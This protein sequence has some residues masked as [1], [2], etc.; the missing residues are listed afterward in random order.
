MNTH[1]LWDHAMDHLRSTADYPDQLLA[2]WR[3]ET[4]DRCTDRELLAEYGW[5]VISCG[6]TPHVATKHWPRFTEA[7]R[8]WQPVE[9]AGNRIA[10]RTDALNVMKNARKIDHILDFADDLARAP[11]LMQRLAA[12][13]LKQVMA[14][15]STL[16][17]VGAN[18]RYHLARNLG[19]DV[20]VKTGPVPRLAAF[21]ETTPEA[22]CERIASETGER[23]R[24]VDLVLWNWG[25]QVGDTDMKEMASL[26]KLI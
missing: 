8:N 13:E 23:V 12:M 7:F 21:L 25:H 26:F 19:W 17:F 22:L 5:V 24:T 2:Q 6:L 4:P 1:A 3:S 14:Q 20:V 18:N 10:V 9:V 15:L 11:G 16:P